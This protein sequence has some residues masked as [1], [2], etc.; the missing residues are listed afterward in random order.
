MKLADHFPHAGSFLFRWRSYLP[1]A[2]LPLFLASF[3][4]LRYPFE[5]HAVDLG[6]EIGCFLIAAAGLAI[7]IFT[8]GCSPRG[9]SGRNTREQ[10]ADTLN[11]TGAYSVVRHPLY[12][13]NCLIALGLSAFS[14]AWFLPIIVTLAGALYYERIAAREEQFLEA[15]FGDEFRR[16]AS[17]VPAVLPAFRN[18][19][20]PALPFQWRVALAQ[21]FYAVSLLTAA[22]F[23]LDLVEDYVVNGRLML[24]PLWTT[25]FLAGVIFFVVMRTLKKQGRL[26][27]RP[28][29]LKVPASSG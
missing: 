20:P 15:K 8:I 29:G 13:G 5:S 19:R 24:D 21:E 7:R 28:A 3:L 25:L 18:Y 12:V 17:T 10:K 4:G 9:T 23:V 6:W 26:T 27:R 22:L 2:L 14:R 16:W 11:T 1:L